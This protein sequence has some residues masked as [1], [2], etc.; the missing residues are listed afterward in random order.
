M[1]GTDNPHG[2][3][4][5]SSLLDN[6]ATGGNQ[7]PV[8]HQLPNKSLSTANSTPSVRAKTLRPKLGVTFRCVA[9]KSTNPGT[10][11]KA[12]RHRLD[13]Q[14]SP[15]A[16]SLS[17]LE[18]WQLV[19]ESNDLSTYV[20]QIPFRE[21]CGQ[22]FEYLQEADIPVRFSHQPPRVDQL[23]KLPPRIPDK[24][25]VP[26]VESV[27]VQSANPSSPVPLIPHSL[28]EVLCHTE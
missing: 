10:K 28:L 16:T 4:L 2:V 13:H 15:Q 5:D 17:G 26:S 20:P 19:D 1:P 14:A 22:T 7:V 18:S 21:G 8:F 12:K 9:S 3:S 6:G 25:F 11:R 23:P 24:V 27:L